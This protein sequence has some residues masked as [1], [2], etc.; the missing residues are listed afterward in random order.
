MNALLVAI[1]TWLS[2]NFELPA[3][4]DIPEVRFA[5]AKEIVALHHGGITPE[6][7]QVTHENYDSV[8]ADRPRSVVAVYDTR[9]RVI[10]LPESWAGRSPADLS[11]LVH[12]MVHHLQSRA[13][14]RYTCSAERE[15]LAYA[16]QRKWLSA[17]HTTLE[18]EFQI[19]SFTLLVS[20]T[21]GM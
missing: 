5:P 21:C 1:V 4:Y 13:G 10:V 17:F 15:K 3:D 8:P 20:T 9:R 7:R 12:E 2:V 16:A 14:I 18:E 19:D 6:D 11:M